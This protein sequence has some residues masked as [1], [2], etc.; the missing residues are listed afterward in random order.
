MVYTKGT[1]GLEQ[2][3]KLEKIRWG[4][5]V[6]GR[7]M[8]VRKRGVRIINLENKKRCK[9]FILDYVLF[10]YPLVYYFF[11]WRS[12]GAAM[13]CSRG[14]AP[15]TLAPVLTLCGGKFPFRRRTPPGPQ[16]KSGLPSMMSI[17]RRDTTPRTPS[18]WTGPL[19]ASPD[20]LLEL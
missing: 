15:C 2:I 4:H 12:T 19:G 11:W 14:L 20:A 6:G 10:K 1:R 7:W 17:G 5:R 3:E 8:E 9:I 18:V 13:C 16:T